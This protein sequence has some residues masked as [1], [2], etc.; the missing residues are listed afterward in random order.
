[1]YIAYFLAHSSISG[2]LGC[3][4]ILAIVNNAIKNTGVQISL[5]HS[6]FISFRYIPEEGL[7]D[8]M[9]ALF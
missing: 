1:M 8:H 7:L 3:F 9:V 6:D 4:H 5:W 2:H